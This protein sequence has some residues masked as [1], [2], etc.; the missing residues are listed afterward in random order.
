MG[1]AGPSF[2]GW[3]IISRP[4]ACFHVS[5]YVREEKKRKK[6]GGGMQERWKQGEIREQHRVLKS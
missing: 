4:L 6:N 2:C 1:T 3:L 5:E